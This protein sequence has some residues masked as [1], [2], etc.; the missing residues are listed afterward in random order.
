MG[1]NKALP[2]VRL[3]TENYDIID[4]GSVVLQ[5]GEHLD[6]DIENLKFRIE[7]IDEMPNGNTPLE[8][9]VVSGVEN[10]GTSDAYYRI[11]FYNQ[12]SA[13]FAST[14]NFGQLAIIAGKPLKLKFCIQAINVLD[15]KSDKIFFYTWYLGKEEISQINNNVPQQ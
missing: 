5:M 8:T 9:K 6:F 15:N 11:A 1:N 10:S 4:S 12:T 7:F 2:S 3:S 13:F 14:A